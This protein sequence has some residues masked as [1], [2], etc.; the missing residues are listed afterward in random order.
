[1]LTINFDLSAFESVEILPIADVHIG[2]ELADIGTLQ[3]TIDYI[4]EEPDDPKCARICLLNGD[5]T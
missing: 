3:R 5:L 4:L 1:M 2:N